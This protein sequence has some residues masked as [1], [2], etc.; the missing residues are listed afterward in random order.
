MSSGLRHLKIVWQ[1]LLVWTI[2]KTVILA[3]YFGGFSCNSSVLPSNVCH[4][5]VDLVWTCLQTCPVVTSDGQLHVW[6]CQ[7]TLGRAAAGAGQQCYCGQ[8][9]GDTSLV[10]TDNPRLSAGAVIIQAPP[11]LPWYFSMF[12]SPPQGHR[13]CSASSPIS[14]VI[15][16]VISWALPVCSALPNNWLV[17]KE[18]HSPNLPYSEG[19]GS[20]A[21]AI[22]L[23]KVM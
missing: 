2:N 11:L 5:T 4:S 12:Q 6:Y 20:S 13:K 18:T 10:D 14:C 9:L 16:C 3:T 15:S 8:I 23:L 19:I 21:A 17:W 7:L 1:W 22:P